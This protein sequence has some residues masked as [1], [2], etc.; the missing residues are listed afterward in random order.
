MRWQALFDDLAGQFE[1]DARLGLEAEVADRTRRELA[2]LRVVDRARAAAGAELTVGLG[3]AGVISGHLLRAGADWLLLRTVAGEAIVVLDAVTWIAGL[4]VLA[5]EPDEVS[6][7]E[8]RL[9]LGYALRAVA[10]DRATVLLTLRD[11]AALTGTIDR[12]GADFVDV[13]LH[14]A[15]SG[16]RGDEV[17]GSRT[18]AIAALATVR[19]G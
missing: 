3:A 19:P 12:V 1:A 5:L 15:G 11:G 8:A 10:R 9:G 4:P 13:A 17:T 18:V 7:V 2:R 6:A 16:R 14:P